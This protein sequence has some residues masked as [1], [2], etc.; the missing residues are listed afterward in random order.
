MSIIEHIHR[1]HAEQMVEDGRPLSQY[2]LTPKEFGDFIEEL[3]QDRRQYAVGAN[4]ATGLEWALIYLDG[5]KCKV[6]KGR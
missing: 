2:V 6:I 1:Q 4:A 5:H 3:A